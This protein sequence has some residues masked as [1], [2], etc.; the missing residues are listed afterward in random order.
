[1]DASPCRLS[2]L[3]GCVGQRATV[4]PKESHRQP[5]PTQHHQGSRKHVTTQSADHQHWEG[6]P[7]PLPDWYH[8]ICIRQAAKHQNYKSGPFDSIMSAASFGRQYPDLGT[9]PERTMVSKN[10]IMRQIQI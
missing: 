1:M 6:A 2:Q 5:R 4:H 3:E 8:Y 7:L 10:G 9:F